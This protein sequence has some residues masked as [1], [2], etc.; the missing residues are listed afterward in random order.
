MSKELFHH[1]M[2]WNLRAILGKITIFI[3]IISIIIILTK[4][5][6]TFLS[7]CR[8]LLPKTSLQILSLWLTV[9]F[10]PCMLLT[11]T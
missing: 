7:R 9:L 1:S 8:K 2:Q 11:A 4:K 10:V 6:M 5:R 3:I